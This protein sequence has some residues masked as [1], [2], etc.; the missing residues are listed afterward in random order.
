MMQPKD[1]GVTLVWVGSLMMAISWITVVLRIMVRTWKKNFGMDDI[2]MVIGTVLFTICSSLCIVTCFYGSGQYSRFI[3]TEDRLKGTKIYFVL[4]F[5]YAA[6][7]AIIKCS[8]AVTLLRI[9]V[10]RRYFIWTI[11]LIMSMCIAAAFIFNVGVLNICHPIDTL[12]SA[13][14]T[15]TCNAK[16]NSDVSYFFSVIE[17]ITDFALAILPAILL[18]NIQMKFKVKFSVMLVLGMA[19]FASCATIVRFRFLSNYSNP[20]EFMYAGAD[21]AI[22]SLIEEGVGICAGS[23]PAL[24]PLLSLSIFGSATDSSNSHSAATSNRL[25]STKR[26]DINLDTFDQLGDASDVETDVESQKHILKETKVIVTSNNMTEEP[27]EWKDNQV[28]EWQK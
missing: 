19:A 8:I 6:S 22:W 27:G 24:R 18:W 9:A 14:P 7:A 17:V 28:L 10:T 13:H 16:L 21:I 5:F 2:L 15:G 3:K 4:E 1:G 12:W 23:L 11:W 25:Q 26:S 20:K